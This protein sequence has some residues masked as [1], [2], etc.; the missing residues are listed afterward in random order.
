M[1]R[2]GW[3]VDGDEGDQ[4][5]LISGDVAGFGGAAEVELRLIEV[6]E[7]KIELFGGKADLSEMKVCWAVVSGFSHSVF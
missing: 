5:E 1:R 7:G 4:I 2:A 6:V 3:L